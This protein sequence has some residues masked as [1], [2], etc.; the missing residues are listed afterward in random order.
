MKPSLSSLAML[1]LF[2]GAAAPLTA[3]AGC[4]YMSASISGPSSISRLNPTQPYPAPPGGATPTPPPTYT[5]TVRTYNA[6]LRLWTFPSTFP[7]GASV[8]VGPRG[9]SCGVSQ[10][11]VSVRVVDAC[12]VVATATK[13]VPVFDWVPC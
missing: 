3:D 4:P 5:W 7:A 8:T 13:T 2:V 10:F 6:A 11:Q 9:A 1:G 12:G